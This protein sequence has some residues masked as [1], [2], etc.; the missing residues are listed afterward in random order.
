[1]GAYHR[2][3]KLMEMKAVKQDRSFVVVMTIKASCQGKRILY[4]ENSHGQVY[5]Y[6]NA[7]EV[8][9]DVNSS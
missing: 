1:M 4:H 5:S 6:S 2:Q 8:L 3:K 7:L 9:R